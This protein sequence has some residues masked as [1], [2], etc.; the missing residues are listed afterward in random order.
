MMAPFEWEFKIVELKENIQ[1]RLPAP[2]EARLPS[3]NQNV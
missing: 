1:A 3:S 2:F